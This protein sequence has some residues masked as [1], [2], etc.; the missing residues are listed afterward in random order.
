M[1]TVMVC[2]APLEHWQW[3][4]TLFC[5]A[6]CLE[7]KEATLPQ[8]PRVCTWPAGQEHDIIARQSIPAHKN[9]NY[10]HDEEESLGASLTHLCCLWQMRT[11]A[12]SGTF[13]SLLGTTVCEVQGPLLPWHLT[14]HLTL[15]AQGEGEQTQD[16]ALWHK[17]SSHLLLLCKVCCQETTCAVARAISHCVQE[18]YIQGHGPKEMFTQPLILFIMYV[19]EQYP[20]M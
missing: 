18:G 2:H 9:L 10:C 12:P 4:E 20:G 17:V 1:R 3:A 19:V 13:H 14:W 16:G 15:E 5:L 7:Q 11:R 8:L 6:A